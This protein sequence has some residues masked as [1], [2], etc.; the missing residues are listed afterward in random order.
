MSLK[1]GFYLFY[2]FIMFLSTLLYSNSFAEADD[3]TN[4]SLED[5]MNLEVTSATKRPERLINTASAIYVITQEDIRRSGATSIPEL[6]RMVPGVSVQKLDSN[7][8]DI[9]ARGF[10]GSIYANKILILIDGRAVYTPLYG[11][12]FW[13]V[14]DTVLEDIDRIEVIRGPGG[15]LWGANAVNGVI[16]IITK[17][18]RDTQGNLITL[19]AGSEE[20]AFATGRHGG[21]TANDWYYRTYGKYFDRDEGFR[22]DNADRDEWNMG[23]TGFRAE[24]NK[25]TLQGDYYQG[26]IG[27]RGTAVS[28]SS[29][30]S[31]TVDEKFDVHGWN[32]LARYEEE[33]WSM[34]A[35]WDNT[36]RNLEIFKENRDKIDLE[37]IRRLHATE[38]QLISWGL[39]YRVEMEDIENSETLAVSSPEELDQLLSFFIQDEIQATDKLKF[40]IGSKFEHNIYT[41][42]EF[43]P[44]ARILYDLDENNVLWAAVSRAIRTPSRIDVDGSITGFSTTAGHFRTLG[45]EELSSEEM[46]GYEIGYRTH[47]YENIFL[48]LALFANHYK[49]LITFDRGGAITDQGF[50]V[51][52]F[53]TVN[54]IEGEAHGAELAGDIRITDWWKMKGSYSFFKMDLR[55]ND[56]ITDF[57]LERSLEN[58]VPRHLSYIRSSFDLPHRVEFDVTVRYSDSLKRGN[59]PT[60]TEMDLNLSKDFSGWR[61][62]LVGQNLVESHHKESTGA[63]N[64][65]VE[66]GGYVKVTRE[67]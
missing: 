56:T 31:R 20:T 24:K 22:S 52:T 16:N 4:L 3:L 10:N 41:N 42:F 19:G 23:R 58:S 37:F 55:M 60:Y 61:V 35:Y 5:L 64:T 45:N 46:M 7:T 57:G 29:P 49:D 43:Q 13:D 40:I 30:F 34:Q 9:S 65:Q 25:W 18:A 17:K 1:K 12:V 36:F 54:G 15:T 28:F 59:I 53:P 26:N 21:K 48:D 67:F 44:N 51:L 6:M 33:D 39:G 38:Q 63:F 27:Q 50:T 8:W 14:Q 66:R 2:L 62:S 11:G 32:M 47:P